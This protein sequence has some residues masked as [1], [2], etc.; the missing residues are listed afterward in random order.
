[1]SRLLSLTSILGF[2]LACAAPNPVEDAKPAPEV[3]QVL[4]ELAESAREQ[5]AAPALG[6]MIARTLDDPV[7]ISTSGVRAM[8]QEPAVTADDLW[9]WGSVT[10]CMTATLVAR[11]V[12]AEKV[13]WDDTVEEHLGE[14]VPGMRDEYRAVTFRHLLCHRGGLAP[15]IP[16]L[17][18]GQFSQSPEEPI[19]DRLKWVEIAL[20]Q[21]PEGP[22]GE[23][24]AYSN[25][26]FIVAGA[27]LEA[28]TGESWEVLMQREVFAPLGIR[29]AGFGA[30]AGEGDFDQPRGH[31]TLR[32][33]DRPASRTSDNP[34]ALGPAGRV[35]MSLADM[36]RYLRAHARRDG[37][38]LSSESW[39]ELHSAPLGGDY[40][41]G[42]VI[43]EDARWHNGSNT[44]W[45]AEVC[46]RT[47]DGRIAAV[48]VN[49][50]DT[51]TVR[52][53][54]ADTLKWLMKFGE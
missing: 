27:M 20:G 13:E 6:L 39:D 29:G 34:G 11:L 51:K 14:K 38:F 5:A 4:D 16:G 10:K 26:G 28:A 31:R 2:L 46:F 36:A 47:S 25:N 33:E 43:G 42:W 15:N 45:Y 22:A 53:I 37:K 49:D 24:F 32:G 35:H 48:V 40:A 50:G 17:K 44:M 9:H 21:D 8:G 30:P 7:A 52:P 3:Q 1:M 18:F 23:T 19:A 54:V 12:E 41:L